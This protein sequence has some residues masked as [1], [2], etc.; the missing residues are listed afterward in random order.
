[1]KIYNVKQN[2]MPQSTMYTEEVDALLSVAR[3]LLSVDIGKCSF[4]L[5]GQADSGVIE[6]LVQFDAS[7]GSTTY[8]TISHKRAD[9]LI[10]Q[11]L[12]DRLGCDM[13]SPKIIHRSNNTA[14][15]I[16]PTTCGAFICA[17]STLKKSSINITRLLVTVARALHHLSENDTVLKTSYDDVYYTAWEE[18]SKTPEIERCVDDLFSDSSIQEI[19]AWK[20]WRKNAGDLALF[21]EEG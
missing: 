14:M 4:I 13:A 7:D 10:D 19:E 8:F 21:F 12:D 16:L 6:D 11:L 15:L 17:V 3:Y 2:T 5:K 18:D 1:M 20:Y 9:H